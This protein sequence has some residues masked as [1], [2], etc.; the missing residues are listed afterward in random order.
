MTEQNQKRT[1]MNAID[2]ISEN[3][4][5]VLAKG[6]C[7]EDGSKQR[8]LYSK[9]A[10]PASPIMSNDAMMMSLI[11]DAFERRDVA[12]ADIKGAYLLAEIDHYVALKMVGESV[13]ILCQK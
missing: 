6:P 1:T 5:G 2:L 7:V 8:P 4:N 3:Q 10:T 12:I 11:M 9:E 13:N